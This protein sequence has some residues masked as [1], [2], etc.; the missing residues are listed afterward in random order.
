MANIQLILKARI[1]M[2]KFLFVIATTLIATAASAQSAFDGFYGQIA[3]GYESNQVSNLNATGTFA[4]PLFI[5]APA[6]VIGAPNQT[7]GGSP[8]II[9]IGYNFSVASNWLLGLGVDYSL[10]SQKSSIFSQ[11][12]TSGTDAGGTLNGNQLTVS[13]RFNIF[14]TPGYAIDEDKLVYLKA[15]YSSVSLKEGMPTSSSAP[16]GSLSLTFP[17]QTNTLSGYIVG[18]GY[19]QIITAGFYGF[20]EANYMA[21][22]Q[23]TYA[24]PLVAGGSSLTLSN[25]PNLSSYQALVGIGYKF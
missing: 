17:S 7:F 12:V 21:Y 23:K 4:G 9:G 6:D 3:T 2:K 10:L 22:G 16:G 19:K 15:G 8:L 25:G 5:G 24:S 20:A 1:P 11:P 18:L 14:L 13:N